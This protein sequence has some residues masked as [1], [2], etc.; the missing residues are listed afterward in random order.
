MW[1]GL[2]ARMRDTLTA[3]RTERMDDAASSR[4]SNLA[5]RL[6]TAGF[7][8]PLIIYMLWWGPAWLFPAVTGVMALG[9]A[10]EMFTMVAP[11]QM[12][13][14]VFGTLASLATYCVIGFGLG[15]QHLALG[16]VALTCVGMLVSLAQ[17]EPLE[18]AALRM[19]WAIAGPLY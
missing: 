16:M 2:R 7:F 15:G 10:W 5:L 13:L 19:G 6:L 4:R 11:Q 12:L 1:F 14:R 9:G 17:P 18:G 8:A 3:H